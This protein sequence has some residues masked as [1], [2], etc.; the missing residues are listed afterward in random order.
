MNEVESYGEKNVS[1]MLLGNK[2][3][4]EERLITG[5]EAQKYSSEH[6]MIFYETSAKTAESVET[7]FFEISKQLM[8]K[9]EERR[10]NRNTQKQV[11]QPEPVALAPLGAQPE[12]EKS[13]LL[14]TSD[15]A[16]EEDSVDIG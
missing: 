5:E 8:L 10:K 14:Y 2:S 16:D 11:T 12:T 3:D 15:A 7:A 13:C 4:I 9:R 6:N 1:L